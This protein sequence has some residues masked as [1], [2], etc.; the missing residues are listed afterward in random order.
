MGSSV[1]RCVHLHFHPPSLHHHQCHRCCLVGSHPARLLVSSLSSHHSCRCPGVVLVVVLG[2]VPDADEPPRE[3][4]GRG[5]ESCS[6]SSAIFFWDSDSGGH[7]AL[8]LFSMPLTPGS[9]AAC[10]STASASARLILS[11]AAASRAAPTESP[12]DRP[13]ILFR[14]ASL[15]ACSLPWPVLRYRHPGQSSLRPH[16]P[17]SALRR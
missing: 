10:L 13:S 4:E 9:F 5:V 7:A 1:L 14:P 16:W 3:T 17:K 6:V 12:F 11:S 15:C 8:A 2:R